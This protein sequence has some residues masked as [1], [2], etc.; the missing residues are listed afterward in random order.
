MTTKVQDVCTKSGRPPHPRNFVRQESWF[1]SS[2]RILIALC[3]VLFFCT[4]AIAQGPDR[5]KP[6]AL[7]PPPTLNLPPIQHFKLANGLPVVLMEK[8]QV[9]LVQINVLIKT[10]R[11][12]DPPQMNGMANMTVAMLDEGAGDRS[13]LQLADAIEF[14]GARI[15]TTAGYHTIRIALHT[16][17]TKLDPAL[18]LL[19]DV[20]LR[21]TFPSAELQRLR[22]QFLTNLVQWHD[23]PTTIASVLFDR[24]LYGKKHPYGRTSLGDA[25]TLNKFTVQALK[26]FHATYFKPNNAVVFVVGDVEPEAIV[27]KLEAAFGQWQQG[28]VPEPR[29]PKTQQVARR[30]IFLVDKPAAAQSVFRIGRLGV[31]RKTDDY[32]AIVVMNTILGGSFTSRLNQNLREEHGYSYGAWSFFA[33]RPLAG[34]FQAGASVQTDVTDKA[35]IEFMKELNGIL[36]PIPE[37]ELNRAKNYVALQYPG[38]FQSVERITGQLEQLVIFDLP[39]DYFNEYVKNILAVTKEDVHRV[40]KKYVDPQK[41]AIVVVGD[42]EKIAKGVADLKLGPMKVMTVEEVLGQV[43]TVVKSD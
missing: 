15:S 2:Q 8:H 24:I 34:P 37:E 35:L 32:Y 40:A 22:K 33:F 7:G 10:G 4:S 28:E 6:P 27:A 23:Q 25:A 19:A 31:P 9:P 1:C 21:P 42:R 5:S 26:R 16:P 41:V 3:T 43:P 36:A 18:D 39:D 14:L 30:Q 11:V 17:L 38:R 20:V 29:F 12:A 13:A